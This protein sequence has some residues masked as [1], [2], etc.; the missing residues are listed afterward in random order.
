[1]ITYDRF[2]EI[3][4]AEG[5]RTTPDKWAYK[6]FKA[7]DVPY[8]DAYELNIPYD[9][10]RLYFGYV[11]LD[12]N[13]G[14]LKFNRTCDSDFRYNVGKDCIEYFDIAKVHMF[15]FEGDPDVDNNPWSKVEV[16]ENGEI[17]CPGDD[18]L[19]ETRNELTEYL[20]IY[21]EKN[22]D[23]IIERLES[24]L[25]GIRERIDDDH[26][27]IDNAL[28][29]IEKCEERRLECEKSLRALRIPD[30][31][32]HPVV[33]AIYVNRDKK[34]VRLDYADEDKLLWSFRRPSDY[35]YSTYIDGKFKKD[36]SDDGYD[37]IKKLD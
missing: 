23:K 30:F 5:E 2:K 11:Q 35:S 24:M 20:K 8:E 34:K 16:D 10:D 4:I 14:K 12:E 7:F 22:K 18:L 26:K 9:S 33:G 19:F 25:S 17:V 1:M 31:L 37:I 29:D 28:K 13:T 15:H 21:I 32:K 27:A 3:L 6:D 36:G